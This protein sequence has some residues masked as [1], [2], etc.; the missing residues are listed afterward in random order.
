MRI[1]ENNV[2]AFL[3]YFVFK[4]MMDD[5][6]HAS[7]ILKCLLEGTGAK[8]KIGNMKK[9]IGLFMLFFV[10]TF[11]GCGDDE[12]K[13]VTG[14]DFLTKNNITDVVRI[15][16]NRLVEDDLS[17][18]YFGN[19][20]GK[21]W[22]ALFDTKSGLLQEEWYG[23]ERFYENDG[24][25]SP[26]YGSVPLFKKLKN[27]EYVYKYGFEETEQIVYLLEN[28]EVRYGFVLKENMSLQKVLEGKGFLGMLNSD[29]GSSGLVI[30]DFDG[31]ISVEDV[32]FSGEPD[33]WYSGFLGD[34]VWI[35]FYD[36]KD[37]LQEITGADIFERN[38]KVHIG[39]GEYDE[40]YI[41]RI[42]VG[43]PLK[44]DWGYA[45]VPYYYTNN[46]NKD[47]CDL[48]L[49]NKGRLIF[50]PF[51]HAFYNYNNRLCN[52]YN[53]SVLV[54]GR[55]VFSPEGE[56]VIELLEYAFQEGDEA[57]S[58]KD[59]IRFRSWGNDFL[60]YDCMENQDVWIS[61]IDK[62]ENVQSNARITMTVLEKKEQ[63]WGYRCN[64]VNEDGSKSEFKFDLNVETGEVTYI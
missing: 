38:R 26:S 44:T 6:S 43:N 51:T 31:N 30:Y 33:S 41:E 35:G 32:I 19:R 48:F 12:V 34:K 1:L 60:R 8:L 45:F 61:K 57:A 46:G 2:E 37:D 59:V 3:F 7:Y 55:Y 39:Y 22:F 36:E 62:L 23:K 24:Y 49:I 42:M 16:E 47:N 5:G 13:Y 10:F 21:D 50:I 9:L 29:D 25:D 58:Y 63:I 17:T 52:W 18:I 40:F 14:D 53:G 11:C 64:I 56:S 15:F 4:A 54:C 27:G 28:Q 20:K